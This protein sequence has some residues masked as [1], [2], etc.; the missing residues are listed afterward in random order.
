MR[1]K[2]QE[3]GNLKFGNVCHSG[4]NSILLHVL[5]NLDAKLSMIDTKGESHLF[6]F[7]P[8]LESPGGRRGPACTWPPGP[9]AHDRNERDQEHQQECTFSDL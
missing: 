4:C 1:G 8:V 9:G 3:E 2:F 7:R 5:N 6:Q